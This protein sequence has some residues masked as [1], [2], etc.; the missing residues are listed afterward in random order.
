VPGP[1]IHVEAIEQ[2]L[3][4]I[5][6]ERPDWAF[7]L[8]ITLTILLG[9]ILILSMQTRPRWRV[10]FVLAAIAGSIYLSWYCFSELRLLID[11]TAPAITAVLVFA[12]S[13]AG[14]AVVEESDRR[15]I[16]T[17]FEKYL[18]KSL[19]DQLAQQPDQLRLGGESRT[20]TAFF[21]DIHGFTSLSEQWR[22]D[23]EK[24]TSFLNQ[25]MTI[26]SREI[27]KQDGMIDKFIGDCVMALWNAPS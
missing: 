23:P 11:P 21:C 9:L 25:F 12:A 6:L 16:R 27:A 3:L 17:A 14:R 8:E 4:G 7:G 2:A 19:V 1:L 5:F 20:V 24:L 10:V 13:A 18:P 22:D 15:Q 26:V